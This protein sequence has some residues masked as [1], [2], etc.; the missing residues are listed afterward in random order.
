MLFWTE[1]ASRKGIP[2]VFEKAISKFQKTALFKENSYELSL[3][4]PCY[5]WDDRPMKP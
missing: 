1:M 4:K 5:Y 3:V 2:L